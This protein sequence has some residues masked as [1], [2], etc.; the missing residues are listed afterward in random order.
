MYT[1]GH[2]LHKYCS[3]CCED[4][5]G[6]PHACDICKSGSRPGV[7]IEDI[8]STTLVDALMNLK[9]K[10]TKPQEQQNV[11]NNSKDDDNKDENEESAPFFYSAKASVSSPIKD[12][13]AS[14]ESIPDLKHGMLI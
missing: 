12:K 14:Q 4:Y 8:Y 3:N 2:C 7:P 13:K 5:R 10:L 9:T 6:K 1:L 11:D